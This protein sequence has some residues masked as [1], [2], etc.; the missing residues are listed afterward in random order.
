MSAAFPGAGD[1][2]VDLHSHLI[3]GV[4]D[5]ASNDHECGVGLAAFAQAGVRRFAATPHL[6]AS[7]THEARAL[8]GWLEAV[9]RG[10]ERLT[11][12]VGATGSALQPERGAEVALDAPEPELSDPRVRL[13]GGPYVLVEFPF[14]AVPPYALQA[15]RQVVAGGWRPVV[16]HPERYE[17]AADITAHA[18]AWRSVGAVLQVNGP[19]L[20]GRFGS[21]AK[22]RVEALL[23]AGLVDYVASDFHAR[24]ASGI[25]DYVRLL[26]ERARPEQLRLLTIVN[27]ARILAGEEPIPVGPVERPR[28]LLSQLFRRR[29]AVSGA[30]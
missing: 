7:T 13:G 3:P 19:S 17:D 18:A 22:R 9:D 8:A 1:G 28:G 21:R 25:E 23:A 16:A 27:P 15:L 30:S 11:A 29:G 20:T 24:G 12:L 2:I 5:G 4:D 26:E 6:R 14:L 10:W